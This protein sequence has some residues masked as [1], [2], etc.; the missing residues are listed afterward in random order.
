MTGLRTKF[1]VG[2][3]IGGTF[4]DLVLLDADGALHIVKVLSTPDDPAK[5]VLRALDS[6]SERLGMDPEALLAR[7]E[8]FV[9]GSTI[10]TNT[11]LESTGARVGMLVTQGFR[12]SL[13]IR[14][15]VR[16]NMWDH[17]TPFAPVLVPRYLRIGIPERID[18][19]GREIVELDREAVENAAKYMASESVEAVAV[20]FLNSFVEPCHELEAGRILEQ[21]F[22]TA[23]V[24]LS[25]RVA[26]IIG[27]YERSSTAVINACLS[28]KVVPYLV[29]LDNELRRRG[30]RHPLLLVQSNGWHRLR[31]TDERAS[32][33][34]SPFRASCMCGRPQS[35]RR[36][37]RP[38]Q[39]HFHGDR[40]HELRCGHDAQG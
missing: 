28:P 21:H 9:H 16:Q 34:P 13:E 15:G 10:A 24:S 29:R 40:R 31:R 12:D 1:R 32:G 38:R 18:R 26:P 30:L 23:A 6:S 5:G 33:Q 19:D 14:R 27:E 2:I 4:T 39:P 37:D 7:C 36:A 20:C 11:M 25:T 17:R 3:D 8:T 22:G 35:R